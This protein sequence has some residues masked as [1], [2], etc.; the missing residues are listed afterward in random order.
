MQGD[1][2]NPH[3]PSPHINYNVDVSIDPAGNVTNLDGGMDGFPSTSID[4]NGNTVFDNQEKPGLLGPLSL[5]GD[6]D[7]TINK[8]NT[9]LSNQ[10]DPVPSPPSQ[11]GQNNKL[12]NKGN[13]CGSN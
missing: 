8:D 4:V 10:G 2:D 13:P 6:S 1:A 12:P 9:D 3:L 5:F 11:N 7:V